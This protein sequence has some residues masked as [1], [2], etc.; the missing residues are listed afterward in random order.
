MI[1]DSS[2]RPWVQ[3]AAIVAAVSVAA[4]ALASYRTPGGGHGGTPA[5]LAFG[6]AAT[7]LIVFECL[8]TGRKKLPASRLGSVRWWLQAH[9]WLGLLAVILVLLHAGFQ[10]RGGLSRVLMFLFA[11]VTISGIYGLFLQ[12]YIPRRMTESV[13][14]ETVYDQIP[15]V[16]RALRLEA[17]ERMEL[18]T[19]DLG[20]EEEED[21]ELR[22]GGKKFYF[23]PVQR[24]SAGEKVE[25]ERQRRKAAPLIPTDEAT[26]Q[27]L[28][29]RYLKEIRP[30]LMPGIPP[31]AERLFG[32]EPAVRA[33]FQSV[34]I[35]T[36]VAA[37]PVLDDIEEICE[38]RRQLASQQRMHEHLHGWLY[39]HAPLAFVLL[40]LTAI[41]AIWSLRY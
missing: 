38:E 3:W 9:I 23:D 14:R 13:Q 27:A 32:T 12:N 15:N 20:I 19:A 28:K 35:R 5:G 10:W 39:V 26:A 40:V 31:Y 41:H 21:E 8:L 36:P 7:A 4:Y 6:I 16:L 24:R 18:L 25:A 37:H 22:A 11:V 30:F 33:Y 34:R 2:H 1:I 17:D 29:V